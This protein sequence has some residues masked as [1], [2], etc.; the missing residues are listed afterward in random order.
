MFH[1]LHTFYT[2]LFLPLLTSIWLKFVLTYT[3]RSF[4]YRHNGCSIC[5][6]MMF[7]PKIVKQCCMY[8]R[9]YNLYA[10]DCVYLN[11]DKALIKKINE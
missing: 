7:W 10:F 2:K 3:R 1:K 5:M 9:L 4:V 6:F 8:A 11:L